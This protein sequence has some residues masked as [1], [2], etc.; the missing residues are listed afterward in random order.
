MSLSS[1]VPSRYHALDSLRATM[2]FLGIVLHAMVAY[3]RGSP[4]LIHPIETTRFFDPAIFFIHAFRMPVF[5]ATAGFLTALLLERYG[6]RRAIV[7]R[8]W[9]IGVPFLLGCVLLVPLMFFIGLSSRMGAERAWNFIFSWRFPPIAHPI[10]LWF[11]EYLLLLY[12]VAAVL[13]VLTS[14]LPAKIRNAGLAAFRY[15]LQAVW[16]PL[17][18]ALLTYFILLHMKWAGLE[19]PPSFAPVP[20][21][22][23][24]YVVPF[25]FG[26][27]LYQARDLLDVLSRRAWLYA[28][29]GLA[30]CVAYAALF[31]SNK[32]SA[33]N[34]YVLRGVL[35]LAMWCLIFG[36]IGLFLRYGSSESPLWRYLCDSS[37]FIYLAHLPV[38][39]AL[40]LMLFYAPLP[41]VA[42][43]P[44]ILAV[45]TIVSL[46]VYTFA[47]RPSFI[48]A[49]LN[50]RRYPRS[51]WPA[52]TVA[53]AS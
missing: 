23:L 49:L 14:L 40:Q 12:A 13:V 2:M 48:G 32:F 51:I 50:G 6:W 33:T 21:I 43:A 34:Y 18:F 35:A 20:H 29:P 10:H 36:I 30:L 28:L 39:L 52:P 3:K 16:A 15:G 1:P 26:W 5:Y 41:A 44:I 31:V 27:L 45:T 7:N 9:R 47:V 19:D 53:A 8:L 38:M 22:L 11:L 37:Y 25:F 24:A 4:W 17:P 42:L 46:P